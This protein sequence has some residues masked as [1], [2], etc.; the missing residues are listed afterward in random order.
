[1]G[2]RRELILQ[3]TKMLGEQLP[4]LFVCF[5]PG[6]ELNGIRRGAGAHRRFELIGQLIKAHDRRQRQVAQL[7]IESI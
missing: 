1:M 6:D 4:G 3:V 2:S 7:P 5:E